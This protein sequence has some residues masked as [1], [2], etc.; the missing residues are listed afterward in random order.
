VIRGWWS[1]RSLRVVRWQADASY[2]Y[3]L[4]TRSQNARFCCTEVEESA[5]LK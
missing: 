5:D 2:V 1:L 3:A 4:P